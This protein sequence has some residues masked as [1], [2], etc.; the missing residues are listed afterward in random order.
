MVSTQNIDDKV[1]LQQKDR[2]GSIKDL[3]KKNKKNKLN[4][5]NIPAINEQIKL[6]TNQGVLLG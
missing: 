6:D 5:K 4:P 1:K 2:L 3:N